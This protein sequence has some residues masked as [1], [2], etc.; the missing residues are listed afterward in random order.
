MAPEDYFVNDWMKNQSNAWPLQGCEAGATGRPLHMAL[1]HYTT[2]RAKRE[3][4]CTPTRRQGNSA[5]LS[6]LGHRKIARNKSCQTN[7]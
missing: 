5:T 4:F 2:L 3:A 6:S 1:S 7:S